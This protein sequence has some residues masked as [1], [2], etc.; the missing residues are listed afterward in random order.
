MNNRYRY[1]CIHRPPAPGTVPRGMI[2]MVAFDEHKYCDDI[3][4]KAWGYVE[5]HK[6]LIPHD[7]IRY[8]LY[9]AQMNNNCNGDYCEF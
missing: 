3:L 4:R 9:S 6:P 2:D 5:Y 7:V 1:Y 8:D